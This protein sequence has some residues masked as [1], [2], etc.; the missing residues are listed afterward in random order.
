MSTERKV[1]PLSGFFKFKQKGQ[2]I[3]GLVQRY[4][5]GENGAFIVLAPA[6]IFTGKKGEPGEMYG[7][8]AVGL[9]TDLNLKVTVKDTGRYLSLE[10]VD[11]EPSRK[12]EPRKIFRVLQLEREELIQLAEGAS[13][14]H[15]QETYPMAQAT[16]TGEYDDEGEAYDETEPRGEDNLPF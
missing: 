7:S 10:F 14:K 12:D 15:R 3:A 11:T 8:V 6:V 5:T 9:S 4:K 1:A 16:T 2:K 13:N